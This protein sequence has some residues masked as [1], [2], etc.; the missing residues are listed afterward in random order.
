MSK[1]ARKRILEAASEAFSVYGYDKTTVED[2]A[3][4]ADKAKA[5]VYYYFDGK[6]EILEAALAE[7]VDTMRGRLSECMNTCPSDITRS[8]G[9]YLK[10]RMDVVLESPLYMKFA[11]ESLRRGN[12]SEPAGILINA[13]KPLDEAEEVHATPE[14]TERLRASI[15]SQR[16]EVEAQQRVVDDLAEG[17]RSL[18]VST[19]GSRLALLAAA[20]AVVALIV[21]IVVFLVT[22]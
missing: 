11:V 20:V 8:L 18:R 15:A 6:A 12:K 1:D 5:S 17:E 3:R 14:E 16:S 2:I 7:E 10:T 13:R 21:A 9:A 22:R 19:R 4:M